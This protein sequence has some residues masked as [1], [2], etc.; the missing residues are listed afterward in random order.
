MISFVTLIFKHRY[1]SFD[2][3]LLE[4]E[5]SENRNP[6][7][8]KFDWLSLIAPDRWMNVFIVIFLLK[9]DDFSLS[10]FDF[11]PLWSTFNND[12]D[13]TRWQR[14]TYSYIYISM[15]AW[16]FSQLTLLSKKFS[17]DSNFL[18]VSLFFSV[19]IHHHPILRS[20]VTTFYYIETNI[21]TKCHQET[22]TER[23]RKNILESLDANE[24]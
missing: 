10:L 23:E 1:L 2:W 16:I 18:F 5:V 9:R 11:F 17:G 7:C 15:H 4:K 13:K 14:K 19:F 21:H 20:C 12:N 6:F 3:M 8:E 22:H 24:A